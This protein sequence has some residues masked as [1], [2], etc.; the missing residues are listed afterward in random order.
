MLRSK[1]PSH[2]G[3]SCQ[4]T[5]LRALLCLKVRKL[6]HCTVASSS[7]VDRAASLGPS[8]GPAIGRVATW[9]WSISGTD[10]RAER[11]V[12]GGVKKCAASIGGPSEHPSGRRRSSANSPGGLAHQS[13]SQA[14]PLERLL[15]EIAAST[16]ST[17][18]RVAMGRLL[19]EGGLG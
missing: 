15:L 14:P 10:L 17:V 8:L 4:G 19:E 12:S 6:A 7:S 16:L 9:T 1:W 11:A 2:H 13:T 18:H 5:L 3:A